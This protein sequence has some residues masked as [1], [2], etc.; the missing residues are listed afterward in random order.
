MR[1][2]EMPNSVIIAEVLVFLTWCATV[3]AIAYAPSVCLCLETQEN[4]R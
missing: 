1:D 4:T 3:A 2:D